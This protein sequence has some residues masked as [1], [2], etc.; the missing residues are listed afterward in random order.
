MPWQQLKLE[1]NVVLAR[2][3][4]LWTLIIDYLPGPAAIKIAANDAQWSYSEA[5]TTQCGADGDP[6]SLLARTR[7]LL[8]TAPVGA[9]VGK[10]GGSTAGVVSDGALFVVGRSCVVQIPEGG[11][12]VYLTINDESGG[13]AN[14]SGQIDVSVYQWS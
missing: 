12:P 5:P 6:D 7:C 4:G 14:N 2:P 3:T 9:L 13:M 11:A 8:T 10:I 1:T